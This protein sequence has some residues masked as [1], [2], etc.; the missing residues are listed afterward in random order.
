MTYNSET[1]KWAILPEC[2]KERFSIAVVNGMLTAIGGQSG[3]LTENDTKTLLSLTWQR[4]WTESFPPTTYYHNAP[5]VACT[6]T[7]LIVAGGWGPDEEQAPVEVMETDTL[8]WSTAAS[9]PHPWSR[10]TAAICGDRMFMA[11]GT[12]KD[13]RTGLVLTC[14]VS[15]LLQ[16][17]STATRRQSLESMPSAALDLPPSTDSQKVWKEASPLPVSSLVTLHGRLLGVGGCDLSYKD[18]SAVYQYDSATNT[19]KVISHM[20]TTRYHCFTAVLPDNTLLV[21]GGTVK[22]KITEGIRH[23][24]SV[25]IAS[26][27]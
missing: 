16:S 4:K 5:A 8:C 7:S 26:C 20:N 18:A 27:M 6:G 2:P 1:Q 25:E 12:V 11:G 22:E 10:A 3:R 14:V 24:D 21:A 17:R 13:G 9:L 15:E 19:W 23:T